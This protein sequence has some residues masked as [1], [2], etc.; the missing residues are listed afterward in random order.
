MRFQPP[1]LDLP[2]LLRRSGELPA[3]T[4]PRIG[5]LQNY[6]MS[7]FTLKPSTTV[8]S[9]PE[10]SQD[11]LESFRPFQ[12]WH[13][14]LSHS[15]SLQ[16]QTSHAFHTSPYHLRSI[17]IQS[18]DFFGKRLGFLK[19]KS[20]VTNDQDESLPGS[21]FLRGGS[22]AVLVVVK[23]DEDSQEYALLTVQARVAA[24]SLSFAELPAG[25]IDDSGTLGGA[26]AKEI[27]EE[28]GLQI[29]SDDLL[30]MTQLALS[31]DHPE[32]E[33]LQQGVYPSP[34]ACDEFIPI[35][36]ARKTLPTKEVEA[37]KGKLTGLR[38][39][40]EKITLKL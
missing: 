17:T 2:A 32:H 26:A 10:I 13:K 18:C 37:L 25:M 22:V 27:E 38:D 9:I 29:S 39:E 36:L 31:D 12:I 30:D 5:V 24:G 11:Q 19:F 6:K 28:T 7:T 34:G 8:H 35:F 1:A 15:L 14:T 21:V 16:S 4:V 33:N 23:A 40:G 3:K 20:E